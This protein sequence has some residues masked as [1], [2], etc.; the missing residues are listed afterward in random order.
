MLALPYAYGKLNV[1][2]KAAL[3]YGG[4]LEK[5][6]AQIDR[7]SASIKCIREGH[8]LK[9][10]VREELKQDADW[11]VKLR[12]LPQTPETY[13]LI[14]LMASHDFQESL[15]NYLDLEE[16]R[17]KLETWDMDLDAF[18]QIIAQRRAYYQPLLPVID[19]EFRKLD[20]QMRLRLSQ[21]DRIEQRLKAM[22][23]VPRPDYLATSRERI[24]GERLDALERRLT[25][26]G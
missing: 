19:R 11:V 18:E 25:A 20:A 21:R 26:G 17:K 15:K 5:F 9:A 8:F 16:L 3:L 23:V 13:Y 4:A 24:I 12:K 10:L 2:S 7:L 6:S 1:Y 14:D 22:L